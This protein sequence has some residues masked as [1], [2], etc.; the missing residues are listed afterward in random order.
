VLFVSV[1]L[2]A[3]LEF[4]VLLSDLVGGLFFGSTKPTTF[5]SV[6]A[7]RYPTKHAQ[8][9]GEKRSLMAVPPCGVSPRSHDGSSIFFQMERNGQTPLFDSEFRE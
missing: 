4:A 3:G 8:C 9:R 6:R 2:T 7:E 5:N 1:R